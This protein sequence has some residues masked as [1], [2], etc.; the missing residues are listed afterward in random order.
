M[1]SHSSSVAALST[2]DAGWKPAH[3]SAKRDA[4]LSAHHLNTSVSSGKSLYDQVKNLNI[5]LSA[6]T[7]IQVS[8]G[9]EKGDYYPVQQ[10]LTGFYN[11]DIVCNARYGRDLRVIYTN[12]SMP[13]G[14][15]MHVHFN[16]QQFYLLHTRCICVFC[17]DLRTNSEYFPM[18][19]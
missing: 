8:C 13:S 15:Y 17:V 2:R 18:Q 1:K 19:H 11:L 5:L 9:S 10:K 4:S 3:F 12:T 7:V 16:I 6:H 14:R